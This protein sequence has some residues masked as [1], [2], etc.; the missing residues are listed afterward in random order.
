MRLT[1]ANIENF[2]YWEIH[3]SR[4]ARLKGMLKQLDTIENNYKKT[5]MPPQGA[6]TDEFA[7]RVYLMFGRSYNKQISD[8]AAELQSLG[9]VLR[10][11]KLFPTTNTYLGSRLVKRY[12]ADF[13]KL[14]AELKHDLN[15]VLETVEVVEEK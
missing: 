1:A 6:K 12:E 10:H 3:R 7:F 14:I 11:Y 5:G 15:C 8:N 2:E 9:D 4:K 13:E